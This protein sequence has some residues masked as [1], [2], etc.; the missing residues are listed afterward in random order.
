MTSD[1]TKILEHLSFQAAVGAGASIVTYGVFTLFEKCTGKRYSQSDLRRYNYLKLIYAK[2]LGQENPP[3]WGLDEQ[4][5]STH[6]VQRQLWPQYLKAMSAEKGRKGNYYSQID[7]IVGHI[8]AYLAERENRWFGHGEPG[9]LLYLFLVEFLNFAVNDL[10]NYC[11]DDDSIEKLQKRIDYLEKIQKDET[12]FKV[13]FLKRKKNKYE[14]MKVIKGNLVE[15]KRLAEKEAF[16]DCAREKLDYCRRDVEKLLLASVHVLYYGRL[17]GVYDEPFEPRGYLNSADNTSLTQNASEL[18][19]KIRKTPTGELLQDVLKLAGL[20]SFGISAVCET[21]QEFSSKYFN[22]DFSLKI[23]VSFDPKNYDLPKWCKSKDQKVP[24]YLKQAHAF[25]ES[26]LRISK[27][28]RLLQEV[29]DLTGQLGELWAYGDRRGKLSLEGILF[30]LEKELELFQ[31]RFGTLYDGQNNSRL[32]CL[33]KKRVKRDA[34]ENLNFNKVDEQKTL[35]GYICGRLK[36]T[37]SDLKAKIMAFSEEEVKRV[38]E[39]KKELYHKVADYIHQ[40]YRD[41]F[42]D[43]KELKEPVTDE[44]AIAAFHLDLPS[45]GEDKSPPGRFSVWRNNYYLQHKNDFNS[46]GLLMLQFQRQL[47]AEGPM[48]VIASFARKIQIHLTEMKNTAELERPVWRFGWFYLSLGWPFNQAVNKNIQRFLEELDFLSDDVSDTVQEERKKRPKIPAEN[49]LSQ[50]LEL[51]WGERLEEKSELEEKTLGARAGETVPLHKNRSTV[52]NRTEKNYTLP[53]LK[54]TT[55][56]I[57]LTNT[58]Y[59]SR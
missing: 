20:E 2:I 8:N 49:F 21:G 28:Q 40:Y 55:S 12:L 14:V 27:L 22:E 5:R 17:L 42:D 48:D 30:L 52:F 59:Y 32:D 13:G 25:S 31:E 51:S 16:R 47:N 10:P 38:D 26:I 29:Y 54:P 18:Y 9:D 1:T 19:P 34:Y 45:W 23:D 37:I 24:P 6:L 50:E 35:L 53:S 57:A 4:N 15:C 41:K 44:E 36:G 7:R 58:Q 3:F 56:F 39:R 11:Y 43:F 46:L 33:D